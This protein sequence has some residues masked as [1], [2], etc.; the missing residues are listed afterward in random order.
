MHDCQGVC[1]RRVGIGFVNH[2]PREPADDDAGWGGTSGSCRRFGG[3]LDVFGEPAFAVALSEDDPSACPSFAGELGLGQRGLHIPEAQLELIGSV[4]GPASSPGI[5]I[6]S[7]PLNQGA[8]TR[9]YTSLRQGGGG[10]PPT[11]CVKDA[12]SNGPQQWRGKLLANHPE[13]GE[14]Y[15]GKGA[16]AAAAGVASARRRLA[17]SPALR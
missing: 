9:G 7:A 12:L 5:V 13:L 10:T 11:D 4:F 16:A 8:E 17:T 1:R 15:T 2:V 14:G 6:A 3:Y